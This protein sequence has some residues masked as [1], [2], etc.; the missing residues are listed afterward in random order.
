[1]TP[2]GKVVRDVRKMLVGR[3]VPHLKMHGGP[4]MEPGIADLLLAING[5]LCWL[6]LKAKGN[7]PSKVQEA[8]LAK[9]TKAG[10][11]CGWAD[12]A[13]TAEA[14]VISWGG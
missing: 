5:R 4:M 2:E 13:E 3:K 10:C 14:L 1:M 7:R 9:W 11:L 8:F 12:S 6:E